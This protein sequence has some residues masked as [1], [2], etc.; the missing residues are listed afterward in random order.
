MA[1]KKKAVDGDEAL[2]IIK[3]PGMSPTAVEDILNSAL[4]RFGLDEKIARYSFV[5]K[6][7]EIVGEEIAK[8]SKPECIRGKCLVVKVIDSVWAQELSFHKQA[9]ITRL[10]R[11]LKDKDLLEDVAFHVGEL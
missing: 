1:R 4:K 9:I 7:P 3:R 11:H 10:K 5:S 6:W 8:R 2:P